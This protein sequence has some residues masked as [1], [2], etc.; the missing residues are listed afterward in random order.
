MPQPLRD[1]SFFGFV[2]FG[3]LLLLGS[4]VCHGQAARQAA[5]V[6]SASQ[7]PL[8]VPADRDPVVYGRSGGNAPRVRPARS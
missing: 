5:Q 6:R 8:V 2:L 1:P 4:V 7:A 3:L